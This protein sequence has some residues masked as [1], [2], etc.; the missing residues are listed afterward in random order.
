LDFDR[1]MGQVGLTPVMTV[2]EVR[3][4]HR[5]EFDHTG[6]RKRFKRTKLNDNSNV[7]SKTRKLS[8]K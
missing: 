5:K 7:C 8:K 6:A 4:R 3:P 2:N 1:P